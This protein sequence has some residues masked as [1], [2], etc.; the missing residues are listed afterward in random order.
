MA[1]DLAGLNARL[2]TA[3]SDSA[4][5]AWT[6]AEKDDLVRD[7]VADLYPRHA[8]G[9]D[10]ETS[11]ITLVKDDF[12]YP[13]PTGMVEVTSVDH[14]TASGDEAGQVVQGAWSVVGD[15]WGTL[16]LRVSPHV[17][18]QLGTLR[19]HGWGRYD[20]ATNLIPDHLVPLVLS[21]A[22]AEAYRRMAGERARFEQW[23]AS[24]HEQDVTVNELLALIQEAQADAER[25][26]V[27]TKRSQR[28]PV[29]GRLAS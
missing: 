28:R 24:S 21:M 20:T 19:L 3:L 9:M 10:P 6:S 27:R 4:H 26:R 11:T 22:R 25:L 15:E 14:I 23:Q 8:R 2:T 18:G 13:L 1:N 16:K 5:E 17:V 29:P 12:F 7:A